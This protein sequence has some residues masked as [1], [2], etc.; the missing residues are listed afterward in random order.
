MLAICLGAA[1]D[2]ACAATALQVS[3]TGMTG[4]TA[5]FCMGVGGGVLCWTSSKCVFVC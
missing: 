4:D 2:G 3:T 5:A 1:G